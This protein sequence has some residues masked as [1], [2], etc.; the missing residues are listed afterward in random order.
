MNSVISISRP[1]GLQGLFII[2]LGQM[3]SGTASSI[4]FFALPAW[5]LGR[6]QSSGNALGSWESL[7][8]GSYLLM[9]LFA[10]VFV[11]RYP[12]KA[13]MLVYDILS[14]AAA[15]MLLILERADALALWHLYLAAIFQGVG[16]AF[17]SP[18]YSAAITTMVSKKNFVRANGF[19]AL[20][21]SAPGIIG[22]VLAVLLF[23]GVGL[24]GILALNL[25]SYAVSIAALLIVDV[26]LTPHTQEGEQAHGE[27]FKEAMYGVR[28]ILKRPGLLG[29]Q[30]IFFFGNFFSGVALSVTS[31]FTMVSL[32]TGGDPSNAGTA[33]SADRKSVV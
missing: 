15:L 30:L 6:T 22:P 14:L 23:R 1:R 24:S 20:L 18:S 19:I 16:Y 26:P 27:F 21:D 17:Q 9:I 5:I 29:V 33:Q 31:L 4:A 3:V 12:R 25:L 13:M 7:Y 10:G 2:W 8:F 11:D 28:Y 32:R